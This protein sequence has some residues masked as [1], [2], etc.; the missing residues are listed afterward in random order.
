MEDPPLHRP[1][2]GAGGRAPQSDS[3]I[4]IGQVS[5][6]DSRGGEISIQLGS[7]GPTRGRAEAGLSAKPWDLDHDDD[8]LRSRAREAVACRDLITINTAVER[9]SPSI[10]DSILSNFRNFH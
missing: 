4:Q 7:P 1:G 8:A 6:R 5:I 9:L 2:L 10:N 3:K